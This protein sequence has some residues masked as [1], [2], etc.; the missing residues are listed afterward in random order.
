MVFHLDAD[1]YIDISRVL[2]LSF[3]RLISKIN[4]KNKSVY[5]QDK[6]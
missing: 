1:L 5:I 3:F 6:E 2:P 4:K